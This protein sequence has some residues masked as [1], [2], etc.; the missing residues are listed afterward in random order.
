ML[1]N[2]CQLFKAILR[3]CWVK[4]VSGVVEHLSAEANQ[5]PNFKLPAPTR[6][7]MADWVEEAFKYLLEDP[8][9]VHKS[10]D[11]CGIAS[12]N[13]NTVRNVAFY[14]GCM[15]KA[16]SNLDDLDCADDNPFNL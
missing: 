11:V 5:D 8:D 6:Q 7:H 14:K 9:M 12:S 3:K 16:A 10:F 13:I 15:E 2:G 4:D 1:A